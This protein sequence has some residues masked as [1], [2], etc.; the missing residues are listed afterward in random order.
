MSAA[1]IAEL[2]E[3][4]RAHL[5]PAAYDYIAGGADDET[6][7]A[8]NQ[9]AWTQLELLP[10]V[11]RDVGHVDTSTTIA[12]IL[13]S[14]P[15]LV[16]PSAMH[17]L[18]CDEAEAA[19]ARAAAAVGTLMTLS[20]AANLSI[21]TVAAATPD[22]PKWF[23]TYLHR[24]RGFTAELT[25]RAAAAGFRAIVLTVD[26]PV[27]SRRR[28]R[29]AAPRPP[30]LPPFLPTRG[31]QPAPPPRRVATPTPTSWRWQPNSTPAS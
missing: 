7:V 15:I 11:L 3:K 17:G 18:V 30:P 1:D 22:S 29:G 21:E 8:A 19:T 13:V 4:A 2:E 28:R 6:T 31:P 26:S 23:Q 27:L 20:L 5:D 25:R 10:R 14:A 16:A 24:D 9:T 12:G